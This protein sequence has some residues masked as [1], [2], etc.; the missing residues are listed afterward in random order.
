MLLVAT[1]QLPEMVEEEE[2]RDK[3]VV[4]GEQAEPEHLPEEEAEEE[5]VLLT[6]SIQG[7]VAVAVMELLEFGAGNYHINKKRIL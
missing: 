1:V 7:L 3:Q 4:P 6:D 5:E 2:D